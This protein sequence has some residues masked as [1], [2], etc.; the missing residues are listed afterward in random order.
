[1]NNTKLTIDQ[2]VE[3]SGGVLN[4]D[5]M[6]PISI[7]N[8]DSMHPISSNPTPHPFPVSPLRFLWRRPRNNDNYLRNTR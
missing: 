2:L 3:V 1:M 4:P 6:Q 5:S 7:I 8:P